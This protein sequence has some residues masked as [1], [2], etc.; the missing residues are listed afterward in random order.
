[1]PRRARRASRYK[2]AKAAT[3]R[4]RL[5]EGSAVR[6]VLAGPPDILQHMIQSGGALVC[7]RWS[8]VCKATRA[9]SADAL[10]VLAGAELAGRSWER[11][12]DASDIYA[13]CEARDGLTL[14]PVR[15]LKSTWL[16]ARARDIKS[17][18]PGRTAAL[19]LPSRRDLEARHPDAF[20]TPEEV[21]ALRRGPALS[22]RALSVVVLSHRRAPG[23]HPDRVGA[24]IVRL[25]DAMQAAMTTAVADSQYTWKTLPGEVAVYYDWC[26]LYHQTPSRPRTSE[27]EACFSAARSRRLM[28]YAHALTT[29]FFLFAPGPPLAEQ[30]RV[31]EAL[32]E[33][34]FQPCYEPS[35]LAPP[36][37]LED[38]WFEAEFHAATLAKSWTSSGWQQ[39]FDVG[40][41]TE[42]REGQRGPRLA[43]LR[44]PATNP[45]CS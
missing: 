23:A 36:A 31:S 35:G 41:G 33:T 9:A 10:R 44:S 15:L 28:W 2:R 18:S 19:S 11:S 6:R 22:G 32:G 20:Y 26:S 4:S 21:R 27:E 16:L 34:L 40:G 1:M 12:L 29:C 8:A 37:L 25:C 17:A 45:L 38:G 3:A 42:E 5:A 7:G 13:E 43:T 24:A 14:P 30:R 39:V